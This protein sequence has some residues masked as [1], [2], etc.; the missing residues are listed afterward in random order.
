[1]IMLRCNGEILEVSYD[2][3]ETWDYVVGCCESLD[4][5]AER[6]V[7]ALGVSVDWE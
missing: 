2:G 1:M 3:G 4:Y 7:G 6:I 5:T